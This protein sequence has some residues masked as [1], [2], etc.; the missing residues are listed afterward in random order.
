ML[1][2][3]LYRFTITLGNL[4]V[5]CNDNCTRT[6]IGFRAQPQEILCHCVEQLDNILSDYNLPKYYQVKFITLIP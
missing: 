6:F 4:E 3:L 5:F 2:V 1:L